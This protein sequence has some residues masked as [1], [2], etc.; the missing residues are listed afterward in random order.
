MPKKINLDRLIQHFTEKLSSEGPLNAKTICRD[1][2]ISQ[3][4]F[5]RMIQKSVENI[6]T[7]GKARSTNY[8]LKKK[9]SG[10]DTKIPIYQV[11]VKGTPNHIANLHPIYPNGFYFESIHPDILSKTYEDLPYFFE[12][13]RPQGFLGRIIPGQY[14]DLEVPND[15]TY[16]N[17]THCIRYWVKYGSDNIGNLI[18][19]DQAVEKFLKLKIDRS[20]AASDVY[21]RQR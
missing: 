10:L 4:T 19:G 12:D 5:S 16:W 14:P 2:G 20:S 17:S 11:S 21:K 18:L 3:P 13:L 6:L 8:A 7:I 9:L 15:I 1:L